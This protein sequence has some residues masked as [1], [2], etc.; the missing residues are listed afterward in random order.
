MDI[1]LVHRSTLVVARTEE[2]RELILLAQQPLD[3]TDVRTRHKRADDS[4]E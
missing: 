1:I 3:T 2:G 4:Y